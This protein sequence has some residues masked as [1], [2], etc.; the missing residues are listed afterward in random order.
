MAKSGTRNSFEVREAGSVSSC[1][2]SG[3]TKRPDQLPVRE[4]SGPLVS[5]IVQASRKPGIKREVIFKKGASKRIYAY[6]VLPSDPSKMVREDA[7]GKRA[8]G[9]LANGRFRVLK[10]K[11][12]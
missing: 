11:A 10:S 9:R 6:S 8:V 5:R 7:K 12:L 2:H 4:S 3:R 1:S